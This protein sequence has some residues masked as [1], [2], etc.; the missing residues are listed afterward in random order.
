MQRW[1]HCPIP[2]FDRQTSN[3]FVPI[4]GHAATARS[5]GQG[6]PKAGACALPLTEASTVAR[7]SPFGYGWRA[8]I[9]RVSAVLLL[10]AGGVI[11]GAGAASAQVRDARMAVASTADPLTAWIADASHRF[12][13]P[14]SWIRAVMQVES[15]G[16]AHAVSPKGAIGLM[17]IM[18]ATWTGLRQRYG[19]GADPY[20][21]HDNI[22]AGVAY[23]R[24]MHHQY[25]A[26][27]FLAAYNCGQA[28]YDDHLATGRPLPAETRAY[29]AALMSLIAGGSPLGG[30]ARMLPEVDAWQRAPLFVVLGGGMTT[31]DRL[32][33]GGS[34]NAVPAAG[35]AAF[36]PS[37]GGHPNGIS[38]SAALFIPV[39]VTAAE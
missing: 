5:I 2:W 39:A 6:R 17:Q 7:S 8:R 38:N 23:L 32:Q 30:G 15:G 31:A 4:G 11:S 25:G 20:D 12:D 1:P 16:D 37:T 35:F 27:G 21:P 9:M 10:S 19:L 14:E 29:V 34:T 24:E 22:L 28:C 33:S 18:P 36:E 3:P 13:V 26:A